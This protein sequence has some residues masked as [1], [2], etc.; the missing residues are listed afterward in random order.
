[1]EKAKTILDALEWSIRPNL[2][3]RQK[4]NE[5]KEHEAVARRRAEGLYQD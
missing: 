4:S 1:M 3:L 2:Y 5:K